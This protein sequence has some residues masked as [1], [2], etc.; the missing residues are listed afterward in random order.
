M[1]L[2][3]ILETNLDEYIRSTYIILNKADVLSCLAMPTIYIIG[4]KHFDETFTEYIDYANKGDEIVVCL[5]SSEIFLY[6]SE[7]FTKTR[8][9]EE[10]FLIDGYRSILS[11]NYQVYMGE[12][13]INRLKD[14]FKTNYNVPLRQKLYCLCSQGSLAFIICACQKALYN[15]FPNCVISELESSMQQ[16]LNI[17][18]VEDTQNKNISVIILKTMRISNIHKTTHKVHTMR[19]LR[20]QIEYIVNM[21]GNYDVESVIKIEFLN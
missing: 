3:Q 18:I 11:Y 19:V 12:E 21:T 9:A 2:I 20:F 8:N 1:S 4:M 13:E 17:N 7:Y 5:P 14:L 10:Q 15:T 6:L 16:K